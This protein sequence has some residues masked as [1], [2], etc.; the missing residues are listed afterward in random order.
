M[1]YILLPGNVET[2]SA[3]ESEGVLPRNAQLRASCRLATPFHG[4]L[5]LS[6]RLL[7]LPASSRSESTYLPPALQE[8]DN[9]K[10]Q[11]RALQK[12]LDEVQQFLSGPLVCL[13]CLL[14]LL[15]AVAG[16]HARCQGEA[17]GGPGHD[18]DAKYCAESTAARQNT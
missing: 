17:R 12:E 9:L 14:M 11:A 3:P 15:H 8:L 4:G 13:S 5:L 1:A 16:G 2:R 10:L 18:A 6:I 7:L